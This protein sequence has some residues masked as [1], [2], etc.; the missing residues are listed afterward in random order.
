LVREIAP[1]PVTAA[2]ATN[3]MAWT[4]LLMGD[5][6]GVAA[7]LPL[8]E[9]AARRMRQSGTDTLQYVDAVTGTLAFALIATGRDVDGV[10]LVEPLLERTPP[11]TLRSLR[12]CILAIGAA[13]L[14]RTDQAKRL[15]AEVTAA[16]PDCV[17]LDRANAVLGRRLPGREED[18]E[19]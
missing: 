18:R 1:R 17:L 6:Q 8:A 19:E 16:E 9:E 12:Q 3:N 7:A 10:A 5:E 14:G 15:V 2:L 11:G 4:R 13:H